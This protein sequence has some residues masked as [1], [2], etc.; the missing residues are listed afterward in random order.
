MSQNPKSLKK[1]SS[2]KLKPSTDPQKKLD[3]VLRD[4][5]VKIEAE[6]PNLMKDESI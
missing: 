3:R 6:K 1:A 4:L 2:R 5:R